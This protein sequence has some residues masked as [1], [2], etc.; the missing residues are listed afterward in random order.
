MSADRNPTAEVLVTEGRR[1]Y[2]S[3][4]YKPALESFTRAMNRCSC[5]NGTRRA[6]CTCKNFEEV[7]SR[8][9]SIFEEAIKCTC[10]IGKSFNQCCNSLH[11]QA[12]NYRAATFEAMNELVRARKDAEWILELAPSLPDGYLRLG[13]IARLQKKN[14]FAWKVFNAGIDACSSTETGNSRAF[15]Q[16]YEARKPLHAKFFRHDPF[17]LPL[18]VVQLILSR[19]DFVSL[20]RCLLVSKSWKRSLT[21]P[22]NHHLWRELD[23]IATKPRRAPSTAAIIKLLSYSGNNARRLL[24]GNAARFFLT[25][26]KFR[27]FL[28]GARQLEYLELHHQAEPIDIDDSASKNAPRSLKHLVLSHYGLPRNL[29]IANSNS[30]QSMELTSVT[31]AKPGRGPLFECP[32]VP[33]LKHLRMEMGIVIPL[34]KL[35]AC[36]PNLEQLCLNKVSLTCYSS[37]AMSLPRLRVLSVN[38]NFLHIEL[39]SLA[40]LP[41]FILMDEWEHLQHIEFQAE[42]IY[43]D[44]KGSSFLRG[45]LRSLGNNVLQETSSFRFKKLKSL[46]LN[47]VVLDSLASSQM[48]ASSIENGSLESLDIVFDCPVDEYNAASYSCQRIIEHEW[49]C[50]SPSIRRIGLFGFRFRKYPIKDSDMPLP[51]FLGSFPN[52]ET[53]EIRSEVYESTEFAALIVDILKKTNLQTVYQ[54]GAI[55]FDLDILRK[56]AEQVEVEVVS[57]P[58]PRIWPL[59]ITAD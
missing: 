25:Q 5:T 45:D 46:R 24:I 33:S 30:L 38:V 20:L 12:L 36:F 56:S 42:R 3:K 41:R 27:V 4:R 22:E 16:L 7:A 28:R 34:E 39:E 13:K 32:Q 9:G 14:E 2:A 51:D 11:I 44:P 31:T 6:R 49:L 54:S 43:A 1:H 57:G 50:G 26:S 23:F 55:G 53:L 19:L 48:L 40:G 21:G 10:E 59:P 37:E 58:P 17:Q 47:Q 52:L 29:V 15:K 18:D 8:N 35:I